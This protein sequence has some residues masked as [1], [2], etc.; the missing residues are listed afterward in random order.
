MSN[1]ELN[2]LI[3]RAEKPTAASPTLVMMHGYGSNAQDLFGFTPYLPKHY[4]VISLE[5]PISL[6][7]GGYAWFP[8]RIDLPMEAWIEAADITRISGLVLDTLE[9]CIAKENLDPNGI[10][11][12][13]FSQGAMLG[14]TLALN[15]PKRFQRLI[16]LSGF[17]VEQAIQLADEKVSIPKIYAAHGLNDG[18]IPIQMARDTIRPLAQKYPAIDYREFP[19]AHEVSQANFTQLL[20]WL[21]TTEAR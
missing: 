3:H 13:G 18:V 20:E 2:Y 19:D 10:S 9:A 17:V 12:L 4:H 11:L 6:P 15:Y 16:A 8:L 7:M 1:Q 5:A 14:W 21:A